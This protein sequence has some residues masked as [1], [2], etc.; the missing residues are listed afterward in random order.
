MGTIYRG[1][2][3]I[4]VILCL[5]VAIGA[6]KPGSA[7]QIRFG[8]IVMRDFAT[9]ELELGV[10]ARV[11]GPNTVVDITDAANSA[12]SRVK[13]AEIT[14]YMKKGGRS[15]REVERI[16]A[17]GNVQFSGVRKG[18]GNTTVT[19]T[20]AGR[21]AEYD[22]SASRLTLTGPVT[23]S[24]VQPNPSGGGTDRVTGKADR[25]VYDEGKRLVQLTGGVEA[26]V[27]TPDTPPEGST[28]SGDEVQI[29]MSVQPYK[30]SI[31]NPSLSGVI[32]IRIKET[33]DPAPKPGRGK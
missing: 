31:S 8:D 24:A 22:R 19:V 32:N 14:A 21:K 5:A 25:A 16:E 12:N 2:L 26:T 13:A 7:K 6:Q 10:I 11:K 1:L 29:D 4:P 9:A 23:F 30:I 33:A 3:G 17:S 28:F 15:I 20:A 18:P 27:V